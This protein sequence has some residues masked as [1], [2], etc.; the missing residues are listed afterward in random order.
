MFNYSK[1]SFMTPKVYINRRCFSQADLELRELIVRLIAPPLCQSAKYFLTH[2]HI[3]FCFLCI[4][5]LVQT[6]EGVFLLD[7]HCDR[8]IASAKEL[9]VFFSNNQEAFLQDLIPTRSEI[10]NKLDVAI[11]N[12][13]KNTRQRVRVL[14]TL[15]EHYVEIS[16]QRVNR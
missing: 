7:Y 3:H 16:S 11:R 10:S 2:T 13:G 9:A 5:H 14:Y 8:M 6:T 1:P 12:A 4:N 15:N